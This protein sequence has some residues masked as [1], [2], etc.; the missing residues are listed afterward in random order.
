MTP[1]REQLAEL[2]EEVKRCIYHPQPAEEDNA[3][4]KLDH[5]IACLATPEPAP[6]AMPSPPDAEPGQ[7]SYCG[8]RDGAH[9]AD[10]RGWRC[11]HCGHDREAHRQGVAS[12]LERDGRFHPC[13]AEQ[14][15][16]YLSRL[17]THH[18]P[19][20][21]PLPDLMGIC[22]Q[23]DNL[24]AGTVA[25]S[26]ERCGYVHEDG[27]TCGRAKGHPSVAAITHGQSARPGDR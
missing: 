9:A 19:Q 3:R 2:L 26:P 11:D 1:T 15:H 5:V 12:R 23:I 24:L 6:E 7:C 13:K 27:W 4:K 21:T 10:C 20:C 17:F 25:S 22:T 14:A 8:E 18:A 16:G